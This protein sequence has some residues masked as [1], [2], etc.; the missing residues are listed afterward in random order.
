M[1]SFVKR[2]IL[3]TNFETTNRYSHLEARGFGAS[4]VIW[5]V[6][7]RKSYRQKEWLTIPSSAKDCISNQTVAIKKIVKP[8]ASTAVA[9]RT[10]REV[11]LAS[12]LRHD[13]VCQI[14]HCMKPRPCKLMQT[15]W[16]I[17]EMSLSL[18]LRICTTPT[19]T[20]RIEHRTDLVI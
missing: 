15:S 18:L 8:F 4:G 1:A 2:E 20:F 19:G 14:Y 16:S 10:Y 9:R 5:Y 11:H 6:L 7:D 12:N 3:G 17:W 13:N